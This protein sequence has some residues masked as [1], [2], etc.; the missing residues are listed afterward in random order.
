V[1]EQSSLSATAYALSI[2]DQRCYMVQHNGNREGLYK[3]LYFA[4]YLNKYRIIACIDNGS[5]LTLLQYRHYSMIFE[6]HGIRMDKCE[7]PY[8]KSF[9]E[10]TV[11]ILGQL[12]CT[13]KVSLNGPSITITVIV[14]QDISK[15]IPSLLFGNDSFKACLAALS[16]KKKYGGTVAEF[17]ITKPKTFKVP[18]IQASPYELFSCNIEYDLKPYE[19]KIVQVWLHPAAPVIRTDEVLITSREVDLVQIIP[20]KSDLNYDYTQEC[21]CASA[22]IVN[23]SNNHL[24]GDHEARIEVLSAYDIYPIDKEHKQQLLRMMSNYPPAREIIPS[25]HNLNGNFPIPVISRVDIKDDDEDISTLIEDKQ[26]LGID[27]VQYTG[28][29]D[30]SPKII[31]AGLELPTII[32][33]TPEQALNLNLF[34]PLLR[35]YIEDIFLKKY[36]QVVSLHPLDA[37]DISKTLGYTTL[38]SGETLPRH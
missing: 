5:D 24:V 22:E 33:E 38:R 31:D 28:E 4:A 1:A 10:N 25:K 6:R 18:I 19:N 21:Y 30:L 8:L 12:T 27:K 37:G 34:D 11:T 15:S 14:I 3:K 9:S 26:I 20:S 7:I 29:A 35:P 2:P 23:V 17:T 13:L 32:H 36:P 16:Y